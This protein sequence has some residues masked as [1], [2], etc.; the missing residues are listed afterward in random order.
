[1]RQICP[2]FVCFLLADSR[3]LLCLALSTSLPCLAVPSPVFRE[4]RLSAYAAG[5]RQTN[6]CSP[7]VF[8]QGEF[9]PPLLCVFLRPSRFFF[10][11]PP[12]FCTSSATGRVM[13]G[14]W[15]TRL[16]L[17]FFRHCAIYYPDLFSSPP[18][19]FPRFND[20]QLVRAR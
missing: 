5:A 19:F 17:L 16:L 7:F 9:P 3:V 10:F 14:G 18:A 1:M 20:F 2:R 12:L 8:I 13:S 11:P 15:D 4:L 6:S